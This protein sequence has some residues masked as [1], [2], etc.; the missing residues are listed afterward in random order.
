LFE[1]TALLL[2]VVAVRETSPRQR[3]GIAE[4]LSNDSVDG[5]TVSAKFAFPAKHCVW[6]MDSQ[7][8]FNEDKRE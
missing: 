4:T 5:V 2:P 8:E 1:L 7:V 3:Q 6:V